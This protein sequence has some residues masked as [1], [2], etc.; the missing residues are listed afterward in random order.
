MEKIEDISDR[1]SIEHIE[2]DYVKEVTLKKMKPWSYHNILLVSSDRIL[3]KEEADARTIVG[4]V[5]LEELLESAEKTP[6]VLIELHDPSNE[7]LLLKYKSEVIIT[8]LILSNLLAGVALQRDI[9]SIYQELFTV[10]GAEIIFRRPEEYGLKTG[11]H[12]FMELEQKA[13][14]FGETMLGI[15]KS[16]ENRK[17]EEDLIMNPGRYKKLNIE[18]DTRF[19]V[20]VRIY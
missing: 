19:V 13:A 12:S 20:V 17:S 1:I 10:G 6:H 7:A 3:E 15:Y 16:L 11:I 4:Y 18:F 8:P 9:N 5:L 14:E 2:T